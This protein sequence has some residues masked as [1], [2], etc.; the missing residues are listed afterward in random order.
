MP[1]TLSR[2]LLLTS[3][4]LVLTGCGSQVGRLTVGQP[5][6]YTPPPPGIDDLFR[7]DV[8]SLTARALGMCVQASTRVQALDDAPGANL[9]T[10]IAEAQVALRDHG[11]ALRTGAEEEKADG[12]FAPEAPASAP[13]SLSAALTALVEVLST[14]RD[15]HAYGA[16]QVSAPLARV[17]ASAGAWSA[18]ALARISALA[19]A[20]NTPQ[21]TPAAPTED[22]LVP[23]RKVPATDPPTEA[24]REEFRSELA[25]AAANEF[26][27]S[28]AFEVIAAHREGTARE[29]AS[30]AALVH[31]ERGELYTRIGEDI[32]AAP[33]ERKAGYPL[34][35]SDP[36]AAQLADLQRTLVLTSLTDACALS[37]AA[38]F[39]Q[40]ARFVDV[41]LATGKEYG[42]IVAA[43]ASLPVL[44]GLQDTD[45]SR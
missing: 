22:Q 21:T 44:P 33:V 31:G 39:D 29:N 41:W 36:T 42:S 27:A 32:G 16:L 2:R 3:P 4:I 8:I 5:A 35:F 9:K 11:K 13:P 30:A 34:P 17:M 12:S 24:S 40:R 38:P 37:A 43:T 14:L 10:F 20:A 28:Y 25:S 18:Y 26:Y 7:A 45:R 23:Q 1:R 6:A 19:R 15:T